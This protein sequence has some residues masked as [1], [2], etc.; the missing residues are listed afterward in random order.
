MRELILSWNANW[1]YDFWYRQKYNIPF[2]SPAH[3][4]LSQIDIKFDYLE[5]MLAE[6][7]Q[8]DQEN[9]EKRHKEYLSTGKWLLES[10]TDKKKED[11][12]MKYVTLDNIQ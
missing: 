7:Q 5:K 3:R 12:L 9:F 4:A 1:R 6:K 10:K 2:N 11:E 8:T